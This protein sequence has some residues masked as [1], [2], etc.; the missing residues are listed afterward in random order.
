M[1]KLTRSTLA[2]LLLAGLGTAH[3]VDVVALRCEQRVN[4][5][6][7]DASK[8]R[9]SWQLDAGAA[10]GVKQAAYQVL[11]ASTPEL[12]AQERGALWDSG[13]VVSDQSV[14]VEYAGQPLVSQQRCH[15]KIRVWPALSSVEGPALSAVEG[16]A[17]SSVEGPALIGIEGG[18][19]GRP[20]E[21]SQSALWQMGLLK[22]DD[23][24]GQWIG[25]D[26][27]DKETY[28]L[29]PQWIWFPEPGP[30]PGK[31]YFRRL[32]ELPA[33]R[34]IKSA[35]LLVAADNLSTIYL[36][37]VQVG[38]ANHGT[39][40]S[41]FDVTERLKPGRNLLAVMAEN[42]GD[43][44]NPAGLL[45]KLEVEFVS[46][47]PL[48]LITDGMWKSS[49]DPI[50]AWKRPGYN[51]SA[52]AA[53]QVLGPAGGLIWGKIRGPEDR[54]LPAR[55]L[56]KEFLVAHRVR[57]AT[58]SFAGL[59]LSELYVNGSKI[60][61]EVL[62]PGL[63]EYP[64]RVF[65]V[66][67]DVTAAVRQGANALGVVLGNGRFYAPRLYS[68]MK[69]ATYG[70]PKLLLQLRIEYD[71]GSAATELVSDES[72]KLTTNGPICANNEY[73]GE[74]FD[75]RMELAGWAQ[76][77]FNAA[78]WEKPQVVAAPG[79]ALVPQPIAP[80]R[81]IETLRPL[82]VTEPK[83][84]VF[85]F[86]LGQNLVGWCRLHVAG[87]A[88]T[89][90]ALR[91]SETLKPDGTLYMD[92]IRDAKVTD[93][94]TLK[95]G[96]QETWEPR[97][98][99]HGFRFVEVRG[100]PGKPTLAALEGRVVH[101]DLPRAG[102]WSCSQ[103]LLNRIYTNI[104]WGTRGNYRSIPTDCP[105]RD[106]RQ[107]WLGDRSAEA[108]GE[109]FLFDTDAFYAKWIQDI[110]D[111]QRADGAVPNVAPAYWPIFDDNVTWPSS[112][113]IIPGHLLD[114]YGDTT[115]IAR[116]WPAMQKW[117][118]YTSGFITN[119]L[120]DKDRYGDWCV[121][122]EDLT[123]I[124][125]KDPARKTA[126]AILGT[127]Y[128]FHC[129]RLMER[130]ATV[131]GKSDEA[132]RYG[133]LAGRLQAAF[134]KEFFKT[135]PGYYDN[136]AQTAC[137]L[138]LAMGLVPE[139]QRERV[140]ARLVAKI[141]EESK[142]HVGTG[143]IGGQWLMRTL[144]HNGRGDLAFTLATQKTYP[145]WGYMIGQGATTIWEL[146]NGDTA[147]PAMN[148]G[149]HVMLIGDLVTWFYEDLAGIKADPALPGFK[150]IIMRPVPVGDL[151]SVRATHQ[152][153]Y[154]QIASDWKIEDGKFRWN[155][156]VP[157]NTTATVFVPT[158]DAASVIIPA[159][160]KLLHTEKQAAVFAVGSGSYAFQA[161][162]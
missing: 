76:P 80:I 58:V 79:G 78:Q 55:W 81:V 118:D 68:P 64:K 128:F 48:T 24:H 159:G 53:A 10:R 8:P 157:A 54:R 6:G 137:V 65:Y 3:G 162:R 101:D 149:N 11:V 87:P 40:A 111:A 14:F 99:Y 142:N 46:G 28:V 113:V 1:I 4:P 59:G 151:T 148:S 5:L 63:T 100:W 98:T 12:L 27:T 110:A 120:V 116:A 50:A 25:K 74:D 124:L 37:E 77:G 70:C 102:D 147:N 86:D 72:W 144:T 62:S 18:Q 49:K 107:G 17:L 73:D 89:E 85:I 39:V 36:N 23:W 150:H 97:F 56:R 38:H 161:R 82:A 7:I 158:S 105:Q 43:G 42:L 52:W 19:P 134:N 155:I 152:S 71:D 160:A 112:L 61:D 30:P 131:L 146:W 132:Q 130:Y 91:H 57:R 9:L 22:P 16:P 2:A 60:G 139:E 44:P 145:S 75:A 103:P 114:Q 35:R 90:I 66:T 26:E 93:R 138:P 47:A 32:I 106:E 135:G 34:E 33:D 122:P 20:S 154:G 140:M 125:T 84:G 96:G 15:W 141:S 29:G 88:G 153:P 21:W 41:S 129:C 108:R 31:R 13:K 115:L 136:G 45:A 69:T 92:N 133:A 104:L 143:L 126:P 127:A 95:G 119:G 109:S 94:Y 67:H 51:D 156:T 121:P 123:L 117:M 83:P